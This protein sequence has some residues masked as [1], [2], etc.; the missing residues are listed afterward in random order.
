M[1]VEA[2][3]DINHPGNG[4]KYHTKNKCIESGCTDQA[5]TAW[6]PYWCFVHN[7]ERI[8]RINGQLKMLLSRNQR[9]KP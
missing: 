1:S 3:E 8:R 5:G 9:D 2:F 4:P 7:V 6:S